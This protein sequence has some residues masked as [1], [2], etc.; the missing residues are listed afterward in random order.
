MNDLAFQ[1]RADIETKGEFI[2]N[3]I[4]KVVDAA[5]VDIEDALKLVDWLDGELSTLVSFWKIIYW[6]TQ[7]L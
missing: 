6:Y 3:L 5:Y 1:I 2:N 7:S 4:K